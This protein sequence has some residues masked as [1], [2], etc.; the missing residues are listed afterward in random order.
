MKKCPGLLG[1]TGT[2]KIC[3]NVHITIACKVSNL[4]K[5]ETKNSLEV[6]TSFAP[7]R[8]NFVT[9]N[10]KNWIFLLEQI[11]PWACQPS[12]SGK[13]MNHVNEKKL[14]SFCSQ[15]MP[16]LVNFLKVPWFEYSYCNTPFL[17]LIIGKFVILEDIHTHP[18]DGHWKFRWGGESQ[19]PNFFGKVWSK[20]RNS[21]RW[22]GP[23]QNTILG[24]YGYFLKPH[25]EDLRTIKFYSFFKEQY[26]LTTVYGN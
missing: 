14:L 17:L 7:A 16:S 13:E 6:L 11:S 8:S 24:G 26:L 1:P 25:N 23:N 18:K 3:K 15:I 9:D 21:R 20:T 2:R 22:E 5:R 19:K 10:Q 4:H 12:R